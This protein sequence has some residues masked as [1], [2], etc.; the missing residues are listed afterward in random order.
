MN[1]VWVGI[2]VSK[3]GFDV[4]IRPGGEAW[5]AKNAAAGIKALTNKLKNLTLQLIVLE[6]TGGYE[7]GVTSRNENL[8]TLT[9]RM[10]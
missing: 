9:M 10:H 4:A 2:D 8:H 1:E 7:Y 3:E 6:A 5:S